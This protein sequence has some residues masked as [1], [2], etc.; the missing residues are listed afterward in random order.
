MNLCCIFVNTS[1]IVNYPK[2]ILIWLEV[3]I[4]LYG[5]GNEEKKLKT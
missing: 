3:G 1:G 2:H 5:F 4:G